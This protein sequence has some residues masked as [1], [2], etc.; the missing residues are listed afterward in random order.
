M[1]F[2]I[3]RC[4]PVFKRILITLLKSF[5][6]I[7]Y[8][9]LMGILFAF[10][11]SYFVHAFI[12]PVFEINSSN[13]VQ[14]EA[15]DKNL[16]AFNENTANWKRIDFNIT[17]SSGIAS[18]YDYLVEELTVKNPEIIPY[19]VEYKVFLDEPSAFDK[20]NPD[21]MVVSLYLKTDEEVDEKDFHVSIE[22]RCTVYEKNLEEFKCKY[23]NGKLWK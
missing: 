21:D 10:P 23:G 18:P 19:G 16:A 3:V 15:N 22:F 14:I 6:V 13:V 1:I 12:P 9:F 2:F 4:F 8:V 5:S 17:A 7:A 11:I 20:D